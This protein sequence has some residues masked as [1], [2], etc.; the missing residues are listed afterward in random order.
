M[1][2]LAT[3]QNYIYD[4]WQCPG[5]KYQA[6]DTVMRRSDFMWEPCDV[7]QNPLTP[8]RAHDLTE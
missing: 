1:Q 2:Y 7:F 6:A 5:M 4:I 3:V 8:L